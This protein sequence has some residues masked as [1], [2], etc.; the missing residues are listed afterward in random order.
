MCVRG[1]CMQSSLLAV[2]SSRH[3]ICASYAVHLL[4]LI[5][6][7]FPSTSPLFLCTNTPIVCIVC[8]NGQFSPALPLVPLPSCVWTF[9]V[10]CTIHP[11]YSVKWSSPFSKVLGRILLKQGSAIIDSTIPYLHQLH[12]LTLAWSPLSHSHSRHCKELSRTQ[13]LLCTG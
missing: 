11:F 2:S 5:A 10:H 3:T 4:H 12:A 6:L 7:W 8:V 13:C 1:G 9:V